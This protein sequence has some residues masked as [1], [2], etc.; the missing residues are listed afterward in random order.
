MRTDFWLIKVKGDVDWMGGA[1]CATAKKDIFFPERGESHKIL[2]AQKLC[3]EC[4]VR[5]ECLEFGLLNNET[6]IWGGTTGRE[7]RLLKQHRMVEYDLAVNKMIRGE[8]VGK[9]ATKEDFDG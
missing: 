5:K 1:N 8:P 4:D 6:G 3:A 7:R 2:K 9:W